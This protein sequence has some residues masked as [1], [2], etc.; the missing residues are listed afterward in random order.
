MRPLGVRICEPALDAP[1]P[2]TGEPD[3][4]CTN[5]MP[6]DAG[7]G[8][9]REWHRG[10]GCDLDPGVAAPPTPQPERPACEGEA[11][12][13]DDEMIGTLLANA[14]ECYAS[15]ITPRAFERMLATIALVPTLRAELVSAAT[16]YRALDAA[17]C[18]AMGVS[19]YST[20]Q[21]G[22]AARKLAAATA[23]AETMTAELESARVDVADAQSSALAAATRSAA[24]TT[25]AETAEARLEAERN[26]LKLEREECAGRWQHTAA[27]LERALE[28]ANA[29]VRVLE[30]AAGEVMREWNEN[31]DGCPICGAP[32]GGHEDDERCWRLERALTPDAAG[33]D[34]GKGGT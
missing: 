6:R 15:G 27:R 26:L 33:S 4:R 18:R 13:Y 1:R 30:T 16:A 25:R 17:W 32:D 7:A 20:D 14:D 23:R 8:H 34:G 11:E 5:L 24:A 3:K 22:H 28:A 12:P 31:P 10:H 29:R 2:S 9:W 19:H 21:M